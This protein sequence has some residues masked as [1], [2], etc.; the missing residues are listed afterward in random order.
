MLDREIAQY[1]MTLK[2]KSGASV[3]KFA[4]LEDTRTIVIFWKQ[5]ERRQDSGIRRV[6]EIVSLPRFNDFTHTF[7]THFRVPSATSVR[8]NGEIP[9]CGIR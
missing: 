2:S 7:R 4:C 6:S 1:C 5:K 3:V 9:R 8:G